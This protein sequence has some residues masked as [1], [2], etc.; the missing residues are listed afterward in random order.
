MVLP[1]NSDPAENSTFP[2]ISPQDELAAT[3]E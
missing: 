3:G 1:S 2:L